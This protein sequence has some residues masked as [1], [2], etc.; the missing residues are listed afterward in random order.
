M[1]LSKESKI[2]LSRSVVKKDFL[3]KSII[4]YVENLKKQ[5]VLKQGVKIV[6][7]RSS[8]NNF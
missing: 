1:F 8:I 2:V 4:L 6:V 5:Q 7:P 3:D